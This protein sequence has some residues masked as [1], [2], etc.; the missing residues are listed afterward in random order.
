VSGV[1]LDDGGAPL[2]G[3]CVNIESGPGAQTDAAGAYS[4]TGLN[5]GSYLLQF[6]DCRPS[7][8]FVTQ[9][10]LGQANSS[11]ASSI[12]VLDGLD[13][14]L[15]DVTMEPGVSVTGT[16]TDG[17]GNPISGVNVWV[18]PT[19]GSGSS[20][21]AQT[22]ADGTYVT[23]P[24][25]SGDYRVQFS[26]PSLV[27]ATQYWNQQFTP[28]TAQN[29][30]LSVP[31][32]PVAS[33]VDAVLLAAASVSGTV[34]DGGGQPVPGICVSANIPRNGG[35]DNVGQVTTAG[36]GTFT[37]SGLP[38][39]DLRIQYRDCSPTPRY[40]DQWYGGAADPSNS[41]AVVLA[42]GEQ[43]I[44][45]DAILQGGTSVAG[46]ITDGNGAPVSGINVNVN[47]N[48]SGPSTWAQTA[49]DGTYTTGPLPP[50]DY[51]VQFSSPGASPSWATQFWHQKPSWNTADLLTISAGDPPIHTGVDASL[52]AA[53]SVTGT[54]TGPT[55]QPVAGICVNAIINTPNGLDGLANT[56]TAADGTYTLGGLPPMDIRVVFEDCN[57]VG[58]YARQ[59]W[60]ASRNLDGATVITLTEGVTVAHVDAELTAAASITG[61]VRDLTNAPLAGICVQASTDAFVGGLTRSDSNGE[62]TLVLDRPGDYHVQFVDC[63]GAP[64]YA[65][66]WWSGPGGTTP[67]TITLMA[68][69]ARSGVDAT[70]SP[71]A[72]GTISGT[73]RNAHGD[74]MTSVCVVAYLPNQ[75]ALFAAVAADGTYTLHDVPSGTFAVAFLGCDHGNP[76]PVVADP[77]D[78]NVNY[79]AVWWSRVPLSLD[80]SLDGG[81]DPIAQGAN[82]VTIVP[83]AQL[84]GF[85]QC[86][87][88]TPPPDPITITITNITTE[89][90]W[91]T[92]AFST[93][94]PHTQAFL[95]EAAPLP[96][97]TLTCTSATGV[98][99]SASSASS[100]ITVTGVTRGATYACSVSSSDGSTTV[101]S[102][103]VFSVEVP[104][105]DLQPI[106]SATP[107]ATLPVTGFDPMN[108]IEVGMALLALGIVA[109]RCSRRLGS[110]PT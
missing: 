95:E 64:A 14:P 42:P 86:F 13:T 21:G 52:T 107:V 55:G 81:P 85:D 76:G 33:G 109:R 27:W 46:T 82:L 65:G 70:L 37:I 41:P 31:N 100:P 34:T 62:Y 20:A 12:A 26:D 91:I 53:A 15:A 97:Y 67:G 50:G 94:S 98:T 73:V 25:P 106:N 58:P 61:T 60:P 18:N 77:T 30:T 78:A 32:G 103:V 1:V 36:D 8:A 4:I 7:P 22:A 99:R 96:T 10:Y 2:E 40:L 6:S 35:A 66:Q 57:R 56:S 101:A 84:T 24:L 47:P 63:E 69:S 11:S 3:I 38:P 92:V 43:R 48:S 16:V 74:A 71:G 17:V 29:L 87:G 80:I 79:P 59:A 28:A 44:G 23:S 5:G 39:T 90:D 83:G 72:V 88:C 45:I 54:V 93:S 105:A 68:G 102:S 51:R 9:W 19:S 49:A 75:Y 108:I 110:I 104:T 89:N